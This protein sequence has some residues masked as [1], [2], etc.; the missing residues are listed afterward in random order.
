MSTLT[1][2][3]ASLNLTELARLDDHPDVI[4]PLRAFHTLNRE[5]IG[6]QQALYELDKELSVAAGR[7]RDEMI[8]MSFASHAAINELTASPLVTELRLRQRVLQQEIADLRPRVVQAEY[9]LAVVR[10]EVRQQI[11][12]QLNKALRPALSE[13]LQHLEGMQE[14]RNRIVAL[15]QA[16]ARLLMAPA[17]STV[18]ESHLVSRI[19]HIRTRLAALGEVET[20]STKEVSA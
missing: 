15:E 14:P 19:R 7:D 12:R 5:L 2:D 3:R 9:Q 16:K 4:E 20:P 17:D 1:A 13:L 11:T 18:W 6:K 10:G 8:H